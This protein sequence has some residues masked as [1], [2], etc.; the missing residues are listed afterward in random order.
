[1]STT[2]QTAPGET[3]ARDALEGIW[4]IGVELGADPGFRSQGRESAVRMVPV[5][6]A[7]RRQ[8]QDGGSQ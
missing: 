1:V 8:Q 6:D 2:T 3:A 4:A 7:A 5:F